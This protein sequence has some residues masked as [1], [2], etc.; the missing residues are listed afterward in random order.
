MPGGDKFV[1]IID[2]RDLNSL[3]SFEHDSLTVAWT[4]SAAALRGA[5][6]RSNLSVH[7]FLMKQ[8]CVHLTNSTPPTD[9]K[10]GGLGRMTGKAKWP[11]Y[12]Y[13]ANWE[14][15]D[16][17]TAH[18]THHLDRWHA[19]GRGPATATGNVVAEVVP[20]RL[21][22]NRLGEENVGQEKSFSVHVTISPT[23]A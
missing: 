6:G 12:A 18:S 14:G 9:S 7:S 2:L 11:F 5:P 15:D 10:M 13:P 1:N 4:G 19:T 8:K 22:P 21:L 20:L 16:K 3:L 23:L 17:A